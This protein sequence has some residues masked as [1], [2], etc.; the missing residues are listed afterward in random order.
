MQIVFICLPN[1]FVHHGNVCHSVDFL[2]SSILLKGFKKSTPSFN[3]SQIFKGICLAFYPG[4]FQHIAFLCFHSQK[5]Y[6][7]MFSL[8]SSCIVCSAS[9]K[10]AYI[11]KKLFLYLLFL[12]TVLLFLRRWLWHPMLTRDY[13]TILCF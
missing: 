11:F 13:K 8:D 10:C 1:Y 5:F 9:W 6:W 7:L 4:H 2:L 12:Y 3:I